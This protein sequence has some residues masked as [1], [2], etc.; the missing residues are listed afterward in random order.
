M[1]ILLTVHQFLPEHSS[2]TE[3][4]TYSTAR[5]LINLGHDV[6]IFTGFPARESLNDN[7]RIDEYM[8]KD[9]KVTRFH[10]AY[11]SMGTRQI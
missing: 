11:V 6:R 8:Y 9:I 5:E 2:G 3:I 1:K 4:L 10:H 7:D